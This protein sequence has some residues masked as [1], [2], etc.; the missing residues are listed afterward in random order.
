M[1][2]RQETPLCPQPRPPVLTRR[3]AAR[4]RSAA[5]GLAPALPGLWETPPR[6]GGSPTLQRE[7]EARQTPPTVGKINPRFP[8]AGVC[9]DRVQPTA[10]PLQGPRGSHP[11]VPANSWGT[12]QEDRQRPAT[13]AVLWNLD[14][15]EGPEPRLLD[16]KPPTPPTL[17]HT[18]G[19]VISPS[20]RSEPQLT[21]P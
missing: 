9:L 2:I 11:A 3:L 17:P 21:H 20:L 1:P 5:L 10:N 7:N 8:A 6:A 16:H 18:L 15:L 14:Q 19:Q 13:L 12:A 4:G